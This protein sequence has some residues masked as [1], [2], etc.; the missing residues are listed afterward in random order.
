MIVDDLATLKAMIDAT[1]LFPSEL[2]P[3]MAA[4]YLDGTSSDIWLTSD[5]DGVAAA[6][7]YCAPER[8]TQGAW[9]LLLIAVHPSRQ[10]QGIGAALMRHVEAALAAR[11]ERLLLVETS[12]LPAFA[13]ARALY[14][15]L[16]YD[17]EA[18]IR[19]FYQAGEDKIVF[20]KLLAR[21]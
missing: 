16:G 13:G 10:R 20:R 4:A 17:E 18:R 2:L 7:A 3:G 8:M 19:E 1:G 6:V 5:V 15:R 14:H 9:N 11:G 21:P 12:G